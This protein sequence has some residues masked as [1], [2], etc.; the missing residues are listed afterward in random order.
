MEKKKVK[1]LW[2]TFAVIL[3]AI[4]LAASF[5]IGIMLIRLN[6]LP[7]LYLS[8]I[9]VLLLVLWLL[10]FFLIYRID[11][12]KQ[13]KEI[14]KGYFL[15][16]TIGSLIAI[17][18]ILGCIF[19]S[20]ILDKFLATVN[21]ITTIQSVETEEVNIYVLRD[22]PAES[23]EDAADYT[24]G[25]CTVYDY[26]NS[27]ETVRQLEETLGV[28]LQ[29]VEYED[30]FA[31]IDALYNKEIGAM[32]L[33]SAYVDI[34]EEIE[35]YADFSQK[36]RVLH[37]VEVQVVVETTAED[38]Q[39]KTDQ[40][41]PDSNEE[42]LPETN[43]FIMYISGSDTR[44]ST[45]QRGNSDVNILV[46]V[47]PD[48]HKILMVSTPRDYYIDISIAP[49]N[50]DKLTHCGVYG[51]QCSR[52]TLGNLY[53]VSVDY[54]AQIN[55]TGF[56]TLVNAVGG[57]DVYSDATFSDGTYS[58]TEGY[59]YMDGAKALAFARN[60]HSFSDGDRARGRHQMAVISAIIKKM[61]GSTALI[62][63][64]ASIMDSLS[65]MFTTNFPTEKIQELVKQQLENPSSWEISTYSVSGSDS[66]NYCYSLRGMKV[67]VMLP[68]SGMVAT[69]GDMIKEVLYP[70]AE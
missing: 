24:Y 1:S 8:L 34:I 41:N 16:R 17:L 35:E 25:I 7:T 30:V 6:M 65:G 57:V 54:Y 18:V 22:D 32:I 44:S 69:A 37:Y 39:E 23:I 67:Y 52:D 68:D 46:V 19:A 62:T 26:E 42:E 63:N 14:K 29:V 15:R 53:G 36:T 51:T 11:R 60:R 70:S 45:L 59:N 9:L 21:A 28:S 20:T 31:L 43:G 38:P 27:L 40:E 2:L 47:N 5:M 12:R 4:Q 33:N 64:Y 48:T 10:V 55:F 50:K 49:G 61:T 3:C 58:F 66:S 56:E 13:E